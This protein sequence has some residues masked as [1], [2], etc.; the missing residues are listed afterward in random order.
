MKTNFEMPEEWANE[1]LELAQKSKIESVYRPKRFIKKMKENTGVV[2]KLSIWGTGSDG[3]ERKNPL[4]VALGDSVTAGHFEWCMEEGK[5]ELFLKGEWQPQAGEIIEI[6]DAREVYHE[7]FRRKLIDLFEQT[8]VSVIN[9]GIAGDTI[10]GMRNR[11]ERDVIRYQP[12]LVLINGAINWGGEGTTEEYK[13]IL[14]EVVRKILK[15]T[16]ADIILMTPNMV[17]SNPLSQGA[18]RLDERVECIRELAK[19][20]QVC[21]ADAYIIWDTFVKQGHLLTKLLANGINHPSKTGHEVYVL[22]LMKLF[23]SI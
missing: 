14:R 5:L 12:D 10:I 17:C 22:V 3:L 20:E 6:T 19:E 23:E 16:E 1:F 18:V 8:S 4:I 2:G 11:L 9:S 13:E 7:R 15:L 21:L